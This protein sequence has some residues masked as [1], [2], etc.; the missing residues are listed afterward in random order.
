[1]RRVRAL[2]RLSR[3]VLH[4][5]HGVVIALWGFPRLDDAQRHDRIRWWAAGLLARMG[6][7]LEVHGVPRPGAALLVANHVSWLDIMAIHAACPHARFVSKADVKGWPVLG[8]LIGAAGTL[9]IERER[10]RDA[11]R[12]VHQMGE[13]L[14]R[15]ETVAVFPEGTTGA[16]HE[17]LPFHAN[18]LQAAIATG[19]PVQPAA[20][21]YR[22]AGSPVSAAVAWVGDATL[23]QSLWAVANAEGLV[24][25]VRWLD[26][27]ATAHADRRALAEHLREDIGAALADRA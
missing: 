2:W 6:L 20:L 22:D 12:V 8:A 1:M 17:L 15:G 13:A 14:Q 27:R 19:T 16:G 21:R 26:P 24:V 25:R 23:V 5:L 9:F 18:L 4:V 11:L 7:R 10:K 3:T